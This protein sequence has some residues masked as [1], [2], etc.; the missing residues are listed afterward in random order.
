MASANE[1]PTGASTT[2]TA[3][4]T[5]AFDAASKLYSAWEKLLDDPSWKPSMIGAVGSDYQDEVI[6][7]NDEKLQK[8]RR[9]WGEGPYKSVVDTLVERKEYDFDG[10]LACDLWNYKEGRKAI[11]GECID[12]LLDQVKQLTI[13]RHRKS[14]RLG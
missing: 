6:C 12:Y 9:E 10:T 13:I 3:S 4:T 8:L 11:L 2:P 5:T 1:I 7:V 14:R